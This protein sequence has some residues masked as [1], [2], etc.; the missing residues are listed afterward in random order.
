MHLAYYAVTYH[1]LRETERQSF[2]I[3]GK[4]Y[5]SEFLVC[6]RPSGL[7][8]YAPADFPEMTQFRYLLAI[9]VVGVVSV[10]NAAPAVP[11]VDAA[12]TELPTGVEGTDGHAGGPGRCRE[13]RTRREW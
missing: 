12:A 6:E 1:V 3:Y 4:T 11:S 7:P 9:L 5:K 10:V 8:Q 13:V 2:Q